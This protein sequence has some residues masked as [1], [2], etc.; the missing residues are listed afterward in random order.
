MMSWTDERGRTSVQARIAYSLGI[1]VRFC[2]NKSLCAWGMVVKGGPDER[3]PVL[4]SA[5][6]SHTHSSDP[7]TSV[8]RPA[9]VTALT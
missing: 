4:R 6:S 8:R 9:L 3:S 2:F 1:Q 7:V 5:Q